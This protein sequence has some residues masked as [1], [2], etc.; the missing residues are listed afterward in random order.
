M[1]NTVTANIHPDANG[2]MSVD[3]KTLRHNPTGP[4]FYAINFGGSLGVTVFVHSR[5][6]LDE[7][8]QT[9]KDFL[10]S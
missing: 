1:I 2:H 10:Q 9:I 7:I 3:V 4:E 8:A 6:N 5:S